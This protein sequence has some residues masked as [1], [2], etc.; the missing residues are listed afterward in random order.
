VAPLARRCRCALPIDLRQVTAVVD[1]AEGH[2]K[3]GKEFHF[4]FGGR[5]P[6]PALSLSAH[7]H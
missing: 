4:V 7:L 5:S 6:G 3:E 1:P 2:A